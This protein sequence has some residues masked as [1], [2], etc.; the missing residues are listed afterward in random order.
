ME[1]DPIFQLLDDMLASFNNMMDVK[2]G[3]LY[4]AERRDQSPSR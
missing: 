3:T 1:I 2:D 4:A